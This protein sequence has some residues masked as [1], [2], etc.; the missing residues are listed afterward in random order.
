[1]KDTLR[2]LWSGNIRPFEERII[3]VE[4]EREI[5]FELTRLKEKLVNEYNIG[6]ETL[7]EINSSYGKLNCFFRE[8]GFINGFSLAMRLIL[9]MK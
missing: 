5:Y 4:T 6:A 1:M 9:D 8:E 3:D 2:E 7:E